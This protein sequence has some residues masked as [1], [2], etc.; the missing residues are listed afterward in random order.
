M[1]GAL[2]QAACWLLD[3]P[4][5]N[6]L[7]VCTLNLGPPPLLSCAPLQQHPLPKTDEE[8]GE[9]G[10]EGFNRPAAARREQG[11]CSC[12]RIR[13]GSRLQLQCAQWLLPC[14]T[15]RCLRCRCRRAWAGDVRRHRR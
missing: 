8:R 10:Y 14:R 13:A 2:R 7:H 9:Q 15:H 4:A 1:G 6:R 11:A 12:R 3:K 5:L